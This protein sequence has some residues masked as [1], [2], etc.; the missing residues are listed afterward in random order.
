MGINETLLE[1]QLI[2]E[3]IIYKPFLEG[4]EGV[5]SVP[6]SLGVTEEYLDSDKRLMIVGQET[7][8][9]G[10]NYD[11]WKLPAIQEWDIKYLEQQLYRKHSDEFKYNKSPF[12]QFFRYLEKD[13]FV[14][15]WNNVDKAHMY[16]NGHTKAL[17]YEYEYLLSAPYESEHGY[18]GLLKKEMIIAK[19]NA[20]VFITGPY[21]DE[22]IC[23]AFGL[24][25]R[26]L[27]H[28]RPNMACPVSEIADILQLPV[29]ALWTYHPNFL[30]FKGLMNQALLDI[31]ANLAEQYSR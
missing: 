19:P 8:D 7:D 25:K 26:S 13:G 27:V 15:C 9:F 30:N 11:G 20:I 1:E 4:K 28:R 24:D 16:E 22:S 18:Y 6:F 12:W 3:K 23:T 29:P 2:W 21:Y 14:P 31:K 5:I 17:P 10:T